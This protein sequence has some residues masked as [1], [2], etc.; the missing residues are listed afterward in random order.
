MNGQPYF[1]IESSAN[2]KS[3]KLVSKGGSSDKKY[4]VKTNSGELL[5]LRISDKI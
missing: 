3:V 1:D 2:W 4:F 5:L